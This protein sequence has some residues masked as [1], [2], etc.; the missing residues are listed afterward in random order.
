VVVVLVV[1]VIVGDQIALAR[2][3]STIESRIE[4][5][6]PGSHATV[7]ISSSPYLV[8]LALSGTVKQIH[9]HVTNVQEGGLTLDTVDVT[10][11]DL[12][13]SRSSLLGGSVHLEGLSSATITA[14]TSVA[15]VLR[16]AGYAAV[17]GIGALGSGLNGKIS[18]GPSQV[19]IT[20][21]PLS[22]TLPYSAIVPCVGSA[23]V[24]GGNVVFSCTTKTLP[25]ALQS[26]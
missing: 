21:G 6:V 22:F 8:R 16:E 11:H 1:A 7:T 9:A 2:T 3:R 26:G 17:A 24:S 25:P 13:V 14:S 12:K 10:V 4:Q 5:R 15:E 19:T 18:A 23:R 20:F